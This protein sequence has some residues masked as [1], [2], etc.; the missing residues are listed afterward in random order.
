MRKYALLPLMLLSTAVLAQGAFEGV[1]TMTTTNAEISETTQVKWS[2]KGGHSR[3][4]MQSSSQEQNTEYAIISDAKG[5]DMVSQGQVTPIPP[6]SLRSNSPALT[7]LDESEGHVVNGHKCVK[8]VYSDGRSDV[9]YWLANSLGISQT[10]LPMFL[11]RGMPR[12]ENGLFPVRM[13]KRDAEGKVLMTQE[14]L[15]VTPQRVEDSLFVR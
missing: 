4:D 2:L 9:T 5:I 7:L 14:V 10:D 6:A 15:A 3:M 8:R 1:I 11:R 12:F 13:E